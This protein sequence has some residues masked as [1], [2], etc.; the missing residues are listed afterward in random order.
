[1]HCFLNHFIHLQKQCPHRPI[2]KPCFQIHEHITLEILFLTY[3][4]WGPFK[5]WKTFK[6]LLFYFLQGQKNGSGCVKGL[7]ANLDFE[8]DLAVNRFYIYLLLHVWAGRACHSSHMEDA[9][10]LAGIS[11]LHP[12]WVP[13]WSS[14]HQ[15]WRSFP[16]EP[17]HGSQE[18]S[19]LS[20][21]LC[22]RNKTYRLCGPGQPFLGH[23]SHPTPPYIYV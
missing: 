2:P 13:G 21:L 11:S 14:A 16:A 19:D 15:S 9:G 3:E 10:Q 6:H 5:A 18:M 12:P 20:Y 4:T 22:T 1:M 7:M 8:K 17:S 23:D